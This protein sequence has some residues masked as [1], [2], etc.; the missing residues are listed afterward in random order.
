[1]GAVRATGAEDV[2]ARAPRN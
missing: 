2:G 1:M